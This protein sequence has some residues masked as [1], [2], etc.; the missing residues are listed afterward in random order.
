MNEGER[1]AGLEAETS[2]RKALEIEPANA[3]GLERLSVALT[4]QHRY[5]EAETAARK[6]IDLN[7]K[8]ANAWFDLANCLYLQGNT[9]EAIERFESSIR[10]DPQDFSHWNGLAA[11]YRESKDT[12]TGE[13]EMKR[14]TEEFPGAAPAWF[15]LGSILSAEGK[16]PEAADAYQRA[17]DAAQTDVKT[18]VNLTEIAARNGKEETGEKSLRSTFQA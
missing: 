5:A 7:G 2:L 17:L 15:A 14:M 3:I 1:S 12:G 16:D 6:A 11:C 8:M 18:L 13:S 10:L 4:Y 9:R